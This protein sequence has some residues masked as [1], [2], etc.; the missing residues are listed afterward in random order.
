MGPAQVLR[1]DAGGVDQRD[2]RGVDAEVILE[3]IQPAAMNRDLC[4]GTSES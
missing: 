3:G 4:L 2:D 1:A